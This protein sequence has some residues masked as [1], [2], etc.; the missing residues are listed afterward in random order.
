MIENIED[1]IKSDNVPPVLLLFG[2]EE[3]LKEEALDKLLDH[4]SEAET[5]EYN[6][7][8]LDGKDTDLKTILDICGSF[9]FMAKRRVVLVKDFDALFKGRT[10]KKTEQET[11]PF[12][13]YLESP[14]DTTVLLLLANPDRVSGVS[15]QLK[16]PSK[17][18]A[19][20][21]KLKNAKFPF[22]EI[23]QKADWIEFPKVWD[24]QLPDWVKHR[25]KRLGKSINNEAVEVLITQT[26]Q[27]LRDLDNE[28]RKLDT[29]TQSN[30]NI[31]LDDVNFVVGASR[32]YNVF[33]LQKAVGQKDLKNSLT[34]LKNMLSHSRQ[35]MLILAV[36]TKYFTV[37]WKLLET[38]SS[39]NK[40][41]LASELGVNPYFVDEYRAA[42]RNYKPRELERAFHSL[43]EA[44]HSIKTSS[45]SSMFIMQKMVMDILGAN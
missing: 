35:E 23:F 20:E 37:L 11:A 36:L 16:S 2:E 29:Y 21:K 27:N 42:L 38:P 45:G 6:T 5:A 12:L 9:P 43:I 34:I 18:S 1:I 39:T 24:N 40:F 30:E 44:D 3:F 17:K 10:S 8:I 15:R 25:I 4:I 28:I 19:A 33:E 26:P 32:Q 7:D 22:N 13:R 31:I 41:Q 14:A